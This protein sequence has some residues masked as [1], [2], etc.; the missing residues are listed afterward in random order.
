[1]Y[2]N[3]IT[4]F[5]KQILIDPP[6]TKL[7]LEKRKRVFSQK[8]RIPLLRN[9]QILASYQQNIKNG[10]IKRSNS[11]EKILCTKNTRTLS[12]VTPLAIL[13]S[14]FACPGECIYCP[15]LPDVP[16]SYLPDEP[17]V[18]RAEAN[19]YHP[20]KQIVSRLKQYQ[21]IGH[22]TDKIELIIK[23]ATW[24]A[25]PIRYRTWFITRCYLACNQLNVAKKNYHTASLQKAQIKNE[26]AKHRIIGINIETRPDLITPEEIKHLRLLGITKVELGVQSIYDDVLE[27]VKRGH[28]VKEVSFATKLLKEAGFK[29]GYH[30][31][32]NL[33]GSSLKRD[34]EMFSIV[35]ADSRFRPDSLKI[36][37]CV[38]IPGTKLH[39]WFLRGKFKPYSQEKLEELLLEVKQVLPPYVRIDRLGRD[40]PAN[41]IAGGYKKSNIRQIVQAGM[42]KKNLYCRCIRCREVRQSLKQPASIN[43]SC[44]NYMASGGKE[45]F[46]TLNA[47][48][49]P[50]LATKNKSYPEQKLLSILRLR[51]TAG[52]K[53]IIRDLHTFGASL[54]INKSGRGVQHLGF[55]KKLLKKAEEICR[56]KKYK[57]LWIIS[58]VG[59]RQYY[60]K[61]GYR[62]KNTYMIKDLN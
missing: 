42:E 49:K 28:T 31:M 19:K 5:I 32:P 25:Y 38:V 8:Y 33:P 52:N 2:I 61:L 45:F 24:S 18:M 7:G 50:D 9:S 15:A 14:P 6:E 1:V 55:G 35:F 54:P 30:L 21:S 34:L 13:T 29:V 11:L 48:P 27:L 16:K 23:G 39:Q 41:N 51:F 10:E 57:Q 46:L 37:P 40:I 53:A 17:A 47:S 20:V 22:P 59:A 3:P 4:Y 12:G 26:T 56:R 62:L 43:Y 60:Q 58:G 36:Y 44:S